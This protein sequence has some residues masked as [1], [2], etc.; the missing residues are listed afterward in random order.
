MVVEYPLEH[1]QGMRRLF[2]S[3]D[4][5]TRRLYAALE[6]QKLGHGGIAYISPRLRCDREAIRRGIRELHA[7]AE[8]IPPGHARKKGAGESPR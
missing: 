5:R 1:E 3:L 2:Q 4:E 7:A 6:A 8:P